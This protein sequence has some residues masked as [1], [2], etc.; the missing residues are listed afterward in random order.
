MSNE[1]NSNAGAAPSAPVGAVPTISNDLLWDAYLAMLQRVEIFG[2]DEAL[3]AGQEVIGRAH[4]DQHVASQARAAQAGQV[5]VPESPDLD[6]QLADATNA[7]RQIAGNGGEA[8]KTAR[9]ALHVIAAI[10]RRAAAPSPASES[11]RSPQEAAG[12]EK[13]AAS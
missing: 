12:T 10:H 3:K 11:L 1:K 8:G 2:K 13:G 6:D 5:A 4:I 9:A 7:L